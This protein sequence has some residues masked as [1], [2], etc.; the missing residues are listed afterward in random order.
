M[1]IFSGM[2]PGERSGAHGAMWAASPSACWPTVAIRYSGLEHAINRGIEHEI[3]PD[4]NGELD[5]IQILL[6]RNRLDDA[7]QELDRFIAV[8]RESERALLM[9]QE[10][11]WRRND[12]PAYATA[13][14]RLCALHLKLHDPNRA[15]KDYEELVQHSGILLPAE[16]WFKLCQSLEEQEEFERALG[17]YQELAEAYPEDRQG[18]LALLAAAN[19]A[20]NKVMRPQQALN[21]YQAAEGSTVPHRDLD[22]SIRAG[23][24][25]AGMALVLTC[26]PAK[27]RRFSARTS[28]RRLRVWTH[29]ARR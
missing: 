14:Q 13:T 29:N 9:Q 21:L 23:M 25:E 22:S 12:L 11:H 16:T 19:L 27:P 17:E 4:H 6:V 5:Q 8:H 26:A 2:G 28:D 7:L 18:L 1:E 24:K 15:Y 20:M 10:I 3:D